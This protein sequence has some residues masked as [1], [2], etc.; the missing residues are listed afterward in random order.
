ME[1]NE[2]NEEHDKTPLEERID[3]IQRIVVERG[4]DA[5]KV[6]KTWLM[7]DAERKLKK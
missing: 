6:V 4:E 1:E 2:A 7:Q 5:S 3:R